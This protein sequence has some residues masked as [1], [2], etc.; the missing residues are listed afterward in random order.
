MIVMINIVRIIDHLFLLITEKKTCMARGA[1]VK[2]KNKNQ[3]NKTKLKKKLKT[4]N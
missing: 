2:I 4:K 3:K 1:I